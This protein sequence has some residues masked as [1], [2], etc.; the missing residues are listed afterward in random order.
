MSGLNT[1]HLFHTVRE[2]VNEVQ[3]EGVADL[4][5][6]DGVLPGSQ[7]ATVLPYFLRAKRKGD[8]FLPLF[9][10]ELILPEGLT[11]LT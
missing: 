5:S 6:R 2:A 10:R 9:M 1:K 11:L 8:V 4:M 3:D 7:M